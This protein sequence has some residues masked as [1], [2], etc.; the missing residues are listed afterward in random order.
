MLN[1]TRTITTPPCSSVILT[2]EY[3][4]VQDV[5]K[6]KVNWYTVY[7][8]DAASTKNYTLIWQYAGSSNSDKAVGTYSSLYSRPSTLLLN[9]KSHQINLTYA[10]NTTHY[11]CHVQYG[12]YDGQIVI[13]LLVEGI[14]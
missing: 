4:G 7:K 1:S 11:E 14:K 9:T 6:L 12:P 2:C 3:D 10:L 13:K 5:K 8:R